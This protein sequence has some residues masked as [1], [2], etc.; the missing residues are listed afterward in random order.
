MCP[1]LAPDGAANLGSLLVWPVLI[2]MLLLLPAHGWFCSATM[3]AQNL[4]GLIGRDPINPSVDMGITP[5]TGLLRFSG[6]QNIPDF[7][8]RLQCL[9]LSPWQHKYNSTWYFKFLRLRGIFASEGRRPVGRLYYLTGCLL[10]MFLMGRPP[11]H[12]K[13]VAMA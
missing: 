3:N 4:Q 11:E 8:V 10:L 2:R 1:P 13:G 6:P 9:H 5:H 7:A 12:P